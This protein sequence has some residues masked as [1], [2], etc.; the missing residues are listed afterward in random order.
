LNHSG[1]GTVDTH[2]QCS[3]CPGEVAPPIVIRNCVQQC[4]ENV[5][6]RFWLVLGIP[7][8]TQDIDANTEV[9]E[10]QGS[11]IVCA[12]RAHGETRDNQAQSIKHERSELVET[13]CASPCGDICDIQAVTPKQPPCCPIGADGT[14][15]TDDDGG[16]ADTANSRH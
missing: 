10:G 11:G 7:L 8:Q 14:K 2:Q 1:N 6:K 16:G 13:G 4:S 5:P 3:I 15:D 9:G 12:I